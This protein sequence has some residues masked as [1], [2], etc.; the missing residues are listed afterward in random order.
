MLR[1]GHSKP[2]ANTAVRHPWQ[3][4]SLPQSTNQL[5]KSRKS[6]RSAKPT[7]CLRP[8]THK[9][10]ASQA[11]TKPS[12]QLSSPVNPSPP[13]WDVCA[14]SRSVLFWIQHRALELSAAAA[15]GCLGL[16]SPF[17][18]DGWM[19]RQTSRTLPGT[20]VTNEA[21]DPGGTTLCPEPVSPTAVHRLVYLASPSQGGSIGE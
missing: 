1:S 18:M 8:T 3:V 5:H 16:N 10:R 21:Q 17:W 7:T 6:P 14:V 15:Q 12:P 4:A 20:W 11:V 2:S 19:D 13:Y 9:Q